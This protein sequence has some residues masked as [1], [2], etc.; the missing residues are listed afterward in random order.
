[1]AENFYTNVIQKGDTLLI[2]AIENGRR[3]Q[4]K[5]NYKPTLYTRSRDETEFKTLEG[6]SLK[7]ITLNSMR[8]ARE[9]LKNYEEQLASQ[10]EE[11]NIEN[12]EG[13]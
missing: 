7:P 3:V 5:V 10:P 13:V 12:P 2:R 4:R 6:H 9:F 11:P 8:Q 1:M